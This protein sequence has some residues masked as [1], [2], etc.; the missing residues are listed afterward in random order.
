MTAVTTSDW[1][2]LAHPRVVDNG[3]FA[4]KAHSDPEIALGRD[5]DEPFDRETYNPTYRMPA[6]HFDV[7]KNN[8]ARANARLKKLG[9]E[10]CFEYETETY[11]EH[12]DG[13][14]YEWVKLTLNRPSI[15]FG[16]WSFTGA[17]DFAANGEVLNFHT[18]ADAPIVTDN[19]CDHCGSKRA[20]DRVYTVVHPEKGTMQVGKSCLE[21]FLGMR[22]SGLWAIDTELNLDE[23]EKATETQD[24]RSRVYDQEELLIVAL[25]ASDD[26]EN[27][28]SASRA[29]WTD[30]PTVAVMNKNW[31]ELL[32]TG[33]TKQRQV[34]ARKVQRWARKL[35]GPVGSYNDNLRALFAGKKDD[36]WVRG[37]HLGLAVSAVGGYYR[38]M[39]SEQTVE[40]EAKAKTAEKREFLA[41]PEQKLEAIPVTILRYSRGETEVAYNQTRDTT[42]ITM[43][44]DDGHIITWNASSYKELEIGQRFNLAKA[45]VK[46]NEMY[47]G[48]FQT[49]VTRAKLEPLED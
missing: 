1:D 7:A 23:I 14:D 2:A 48:S 43:I 20:R 47:R 27:F 15:S 9:I 6:N 8:I 10:E 31:A 42:F 38:A 3:Q 19:H 34:L 37:K 26:G 39:Q 32:A 40:V 16:G 13:R 33:D 17:H 21:A 49:N 4:E 29:S 18:T 36:T 11:I 45:T 28:V 12:R 25:A 24:S 41:A 35:E 44:D 22:P 46:R 5:E 30:P